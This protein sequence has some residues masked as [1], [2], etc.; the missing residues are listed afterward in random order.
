MNKH[1]TKAVGVSLTTV[2]VLSA[3]GGDRSSTELSLDPGAEACV[4]VQTAES[5]GVPS[6]QRIFSWIEDLVGLGYRRTGTVA[7]YA[8]AAYV[9]CQLE[10]LGV[11]EVFYETA[12]TWQWTAEE[13]SV[14]V[15]GTPI[16]A[17]P[18][19][20][21]FVTPDQPSRFAT[22]AGGLR[23]ELVDVGLGTPVEIAAADLEGKIAVFDLKFLLPPAG[24]AALTEFLWDP[25]ASIAQPS[26]IT[27]NPYITN[28][29]TV[30]AE[31]M[32]A[33][34]VGFIG[35][36]ADY[37]NSNQYYN[38]YYRRLQVT[39]P[40]YWVSPVE[41]AAL[42]QRMSEQAGLT[43][44]LVMRGER[45]EVEARSVVG[46]LHG[47]SNE[48]IMV[49]SHH[50]AAFDGAVEDGSGVAAVLAQAQYFASQPP[51]S[52]ARTLM[53]VTMD[54]HFTGYQGHMALVDK[55]ILDPQSPYDIVANVTLEH[56][57]KQGVVDADG[58]LEIQDQHEIR[59]VFENV[60]PTLKAQIIQSVV[61][62]DLRRLA[63]LNGEA[64]CATVG[65]PT[66]AS[67][68]CINGVPTVSLI[69]GPNYLYDAADTLDKVDQSQLVP[70]TEAF[71]EI[72]EAIDDTPRALIGVTSGAGG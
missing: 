38:E 58:E 59:G 46:I 64:L 21:S 33:G 25:E 57:G 26:L 29:D 45:R 70:V 4:A 7:G 66:D 30:L 68:V 42:R 37:F 40:G 53:F 3:C 13:A 12:T 71:I 18:S 6:T 9:K 56:I 39:I 62:H 8:A 50:D 55:Y 1:I 72:I 67:F 61:D 11:D 28:Y 34:A 43:A 52:R 69:A 10:A 19:A 14:H 20:H 48:T 22:P 2:L 5:T 36:L 23:A 47:D 31:V 15:D 16:D 63:V 51:E 32:D 60:G 49:Q 27:G 65:I 17:F 35:V 41:G 54:S 44:S 24:L